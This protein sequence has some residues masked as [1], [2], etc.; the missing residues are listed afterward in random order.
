MLAAAGFFSAA[1]DGMA[2]VKLCLDIF[3]EDDDGSVAAGADV[4]MAELVGDDLRIGMSSNCVSV[5]MPSVTVYGVQYIY[6][7]I[8]IT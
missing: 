1:A 2:G 4:V 5:P 6:I 3:G 8:Y 7:Y